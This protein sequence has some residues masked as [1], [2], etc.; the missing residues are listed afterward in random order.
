M[1]LL[2]TL[3]AS[4]LAFSFFTAAAQAEDRFV[5]CLN[6]DIVR[7]PGTVVD[8]AIATDDLSTLVTAVVAAGLDGA[9]ADAEDIT[10]Y[11]PTNAAFDA[12]PAS[13]LDGIL[14][15][16]AL[17]TTVLTYHVTPGI[18]DPRRFIKPV[19]RGTL[20]EQQVFYHRFDG[21]ARV[22]HAGVACQGVRTDNGVVWI[23]DS[24]LLPQ[25]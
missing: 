19:P 2:R 13:F 10:V 5:A 16:P 4:A 15:D 6:A 21:H 24:V 18:H 8:A 17:L 20:A 14:A 11:A 25:S 7:F 3:A 22:N 23:I 9:L 1:K 12:L